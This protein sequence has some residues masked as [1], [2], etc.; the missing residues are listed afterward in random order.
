M[1]LNISDRLLQKK[2]KTSW[3]HKNLLAISKELAVFNSTTQVLHNSRGNRSASSVSEALQ[4]LRLVS[5][6]NYF[7]SSSFPGRIMTFSSS[8]PLAC[9]T[10]C[11]LC[12]EVGRCTACQDPTYLLD[13][14]CT[15]SCGHG[16]YADD[17]T[18]TCHGN[19]YKKKNI[20]KNLRIA[21][22]W[23]R[24]NEEIDVWLVWPPQQT[25]SRDGRVIKL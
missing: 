23:H 9:T 17:K 1:Q 14:Y 22:K 4:T 5:H 15:P 16:Y 10:D 12:D 25:S 6:V 20:K 7:I 3:Q 2:K 21:S 24:R 19:Y 8:P 13:G 18:R 11:A